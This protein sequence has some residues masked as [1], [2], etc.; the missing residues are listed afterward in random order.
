MQKHRFYP[1]FYYEK[2]FLR[3]SRIGT[4]TSFDKRLMS[5]YPVPSK[6]AFRYANACAYMPW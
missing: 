5:H 1:A 6:F 3:L 2:V 4:E